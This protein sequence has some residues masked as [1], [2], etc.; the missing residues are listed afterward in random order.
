[1]SAFR[2]GGPI[3]VWI[4]VL[5]YNVLETPLSPYLHKLP[6]LFSKKEYQEWAEIRDRTSK[7]FWERVKHPRSYQE[8]LSDKE[9]KEEREYLEAF[10]EERRLKAEIEAMEGEVASYENEVSHRVSRYQGVGWG[11][12]RFRLLKTDTS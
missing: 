8:K 11:C 7:R 1:V 3:S 10:E 5:L 4:E 12:P 6:G 9:S 2:G